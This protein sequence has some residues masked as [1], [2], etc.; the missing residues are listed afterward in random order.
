LLYLMVLMKTTKGQKLVVVTFIYFIVG[1]I[2]CFASSVSIDGW[3]GYNNII[4]SMDSDRFEY[5][6][7]EIKHR[8]DMEANMHFPKYSIGIGYGLLQQPSINQFVLK[9]AMTEKRKFSLG[10]EMDYSKNASGVILSGKHSIYTPRIPLMLDGEIAIF[11]KYGRVSAI[12]KGLFSRTDY[13]YLSSGFIDVKDNRIKKIVGLGIHYKPDRYSDITTEIRYNSKNGY[14]LLFEPRI[15]VSNIFLLSL[16]LY[17]A[18][19][20]NSAFGMAL[21]YAPI[22]KWKVKKPIKEVVV[23]PE[24]KPQEKPEEKPEEKVTEKPVKPQPEKITKSPE[25]LRK[26]LN[27][28]VNGPYTRGVNLYCEDKFE[29]AIKEWEKVL[30]LLNNEDFVNCKEALDYRERCKRNIENA[31]VKLKIIQEE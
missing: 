16:E 14:E 17:C 22:G 21:Y 15:R 30:G 18:Q 11:E 23:K 10:I 1:I 29:E 6:G 5:N 8:M 28:I 4:K 31:R 7:Y 3:A 20:N 19:H 9:G 26:M 25:E 12:V 27:E 2:P 24:K 13:L